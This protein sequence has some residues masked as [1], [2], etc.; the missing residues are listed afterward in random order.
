MKSNHYSC[1]ILMKL[2]FFEIFSKNTHLIS[3]IPVQRRPSCTMRTDGRTDSYD[4]VILAF[5][6]FANAP[7]TVKLSLG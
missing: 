5:H 4:E 6:N 2:E 1:Q 7:K 3:W